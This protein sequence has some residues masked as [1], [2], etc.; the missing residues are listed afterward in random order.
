M[1][2]PGKAKDNLYFI[3]FSFKI[4]KNVDIGNKGGS[5]FPTTILFSN[6]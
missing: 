1:N 5:F 4:M 3:Q 2:M 6:F